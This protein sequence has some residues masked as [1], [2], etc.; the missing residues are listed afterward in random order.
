MSVAPSFTA[1]P[2]LSAFYA[3]RTRCY[4]V[5]RSFA[6][7][8]LEHQAFGVMIWGRPEIPDLEEMVAAHE[9]GA[10]PRFS[11]H[12]SLIDLRSLEFV[13][14]HSFERYLSMLRERRDA[15][16]PTVSRQAVLHHGGIPHAI[17]AGMFQFLSPKHQVSFFD[18]P[19]AAYEHIGAR[20]V[21]Q[22]LEALRLRIIGTPDIVRRVQ[23]ALSELPPKTDVE[24][25]ARRVGMSVR[26][27]Q[28]QLAE[29]GSSL[30][31]ER[32]HH[33]VRTSERLLE[34]TELDLEAIAAQVGASS[35]AHLVTLFR[36]LRGKT[37]GS[38][39][40]LAQELRVED[41]ERPPR[42]D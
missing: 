12:T 22:E 2:D 32:Q 5:R 27:L 10:D 20:H 26:S 31:K 23:G 42:L 33:I 17:V 40:K 18:D 28:R 41:D 9:V 6:Y 19:G 4:L 39:R 36:R 3:P 35:A 29:A 14:A 21:Q 11:G 8:Q 30:R 38:V 34:Q 37:P 24:A 25:I 16:S 13:S 7:W 15:W 1:V